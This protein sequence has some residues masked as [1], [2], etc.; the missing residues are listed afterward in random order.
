MA[1]QLTQVSGQQ[2]LVAI[3]GWQVILKAKDPVGM[4]CNTQHLPHRQSNSSEEVLVI[5]DRQE[6]EW[7][8]DSYFVVDN[9]G[10][11]DIEWFPEPPNLPLLGRIILVLRPKKFLDEALSQ[12]VWQIDE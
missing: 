7:E 4:V 6:N 5:V 10:E 1:F 2:T 9:A 8:K 11:L 3:P 12:D